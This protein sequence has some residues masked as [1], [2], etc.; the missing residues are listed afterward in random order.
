[1]PQEFCL[2][3]LKTS[4]YVNSVF[5]G[6]YNECD[7]DEKFQEILWDYSMETLHLAEDRGKEEILLQRHM[8]EVEIKEIYELSRDL[9]SSFAI[10]SE[11]VSFG[12]NP[13]EYEF[14][15]HENKQYYPPVGILRSV[16]VT[17]LGRSEE[18]TV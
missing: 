7:R 18:H 5:S 11:R 8:R 12:E 16:V 15:K 17:V 3:V 6:I 9:Y 4:L 13:K 10:D 1:M 14:L 2:S